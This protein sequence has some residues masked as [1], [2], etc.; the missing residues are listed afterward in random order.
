[1]AELPPHTVRHGNK[2]KVRLFV[3]RDLRAQIGKAFVTEILDT[4]SVTEAKRLQPFALAKLR[5]R[6]QQAEGK[7]LDALSRAY[8]TFKLLGPDDK[9]SEGALEREKELVV[10]V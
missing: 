4:D 6:L 7:S 10:P 5:A 9:V 1:M 8:R 2:F 3:P